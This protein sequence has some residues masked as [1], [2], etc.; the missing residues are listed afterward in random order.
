MLNYLGKVHLKYWYQNMKIYPKESFL[1]YENISQIE[2]FDVW[3]NIPKRVSNVWKY[4]LKRVYQC[5]KI[6]PIVS[7]YL[8]TM[9]A[10]RVGTEGFNFVWDDFYCFQSIA[11]RPTSIVSRTCSWT[12]ARIVLIRRWKCLIKAHQMDHRIL[13]L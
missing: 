9:N 10:H 3:K 7:R 2:F 13:K 5:M 6:Y 1:M 11:F 4:I 8:C 12:F